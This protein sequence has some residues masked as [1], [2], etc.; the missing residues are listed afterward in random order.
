MHPLKWKCVKTSVGLTIGKIEVVR[1]CM[2]K[3]RSRSRRGGIGVG[4]EGVGVD[5]EGVG[6]GG[7][8]G[9]GGDCVEVSPTF[10]SPTFQYVKHVPGEAMLWGLH[11]RSV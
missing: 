7:E 10:L 2:Y 11:T 1:T 3:G 6:V 4:G 9:E 5:G 8:G